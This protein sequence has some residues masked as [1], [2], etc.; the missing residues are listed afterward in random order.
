SVQDTMSYS[1]KQKNISGQ[2]TVGYGTSVSAS[3][4]Q[5]KINADYA[6]VQE[7][8]GLFAG[9][10][11]YQV[12]VRQHTDLTG[13]LIT[14]TAQAEADG[15]NS[16]STGTLSYS[17][18]ENHTNYS[19]SA[20]G[21][22]GSVAMNF[23]T[24]LGKYGQA[25]SNKQAVNE[26]GEK[27]YINSQGNPTTASRDSAGNANKPKLAEGL[28]SLTGD[29]SFGFGSDSS[30]QSNVTKSG[31]N[32]ANIHIRNEKAQQSLAGKSVEET[33]KGIKT[34]ITAESA[35]QNSGKLE[36]HFNK[37]EIIR[38]IQLQVK[39][40]SNFIDNAQEAK[41]QI[42]DYYQEPKRK[43]LRQAI[44]DYHNAK[45]EGK[46]QYENKID[47]LIRDI[48]TLEHIRT[49]LDLAT[50]LIT[51]APKVMSAKT[52]ISII[53]TEARKESLRNSLLA[54]PIEDIK[55]GGKLYS[56]VGHN[57]GS[58][59]GIKLG[60]VRM[61][62][63]V[64]CGKNNERCETDGKGNLKLNEQG[65]IVYNAK[66]KYTTVSDL[67]NDRSKSGKLFGATGGFQAIE[68]EMFG[69]KY[70][71]GSFLDRLTETYSGE[72][73]LIGGQLFFY[74]ELGNGKRNLTERQQFWIDRAAE[75]AVIGVTPTT[76][77]HALPLEAMYLLFGVR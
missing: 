14:S 2:A 13:G 37:D 62:Y 71:P 54:I 31:I 6:S 27:L 47:E 18:I 19:G 26:Q 16:F 58:F 39:T 65:H 48:Y 12:N 45:A 15:K 21:V 22:S 67:L 46:T 50:G 73:D 52:L 28:D 42:I 60:G 34:D 33:L 9:D 75:A 51:G 70:K 74:D 29:V 23:N 77:P 4:N 32:T 30:S 43:A 41:N 1:G 66:D 57:S 76:V 3:F 38:E 20:F 49:G 7:Q 10:E 72:H 64:I 25:Q 5:S 36:N 56:N 59:D 44:T 40:T 11:G 17:D 69:I 24:P 53:D 63:D 61:N 55:D 8:S 35:E 68:G